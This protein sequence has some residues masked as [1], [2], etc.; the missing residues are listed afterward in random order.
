[1]CKNRFIKK[2]DDCSDLAI[3][4]ILTP[5]RIGVF[6][7]F[8]IRE[9]FSNVCPIS[10][11]KYMEVTYVLS[12]FSEPV[13][14]SLSSNAGQGSFTLCKYARPT[15]WDS[16]GPCTREPDSKEERTPTVVVGSRH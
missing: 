13:D 7:Y 6:I 14:S 5:A 2:L 3:I 16:G 9:L 4:Y 15:D 11:Q 8:N 10:G 1:M 12:G